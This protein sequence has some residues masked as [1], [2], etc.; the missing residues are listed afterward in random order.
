YN[1][2]L[3]TEI[4]KITI[5]SVVKYIAPEFEAF[6]NLAS[7]IETNDYYFNRMTVEQST[8]LDYLEEQEIAGIQGTAGTG[9]TMI[10][11][12]KAKRLSEK[13]KIVFLCFN[14][15]LVEYLRNRYETELPN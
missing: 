1:G 3:E 11:I 2:M 10:A 8:L 12:E 6:P 9:K 4:D 7:V 5:N 15:L 13:E 14:S